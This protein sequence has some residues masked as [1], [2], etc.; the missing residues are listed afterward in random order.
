MTP[1]PLARLRTICLAFPEAHEVLA[2]GEPTFRVRNRLFAMFA[3]PSHHHGAGRPAVW[4]KATPINQAL[5]VKAKPSRFFVPPYVGKSGWVGVWLD[6]RP[7]WGEVASLL[8]DAWSAT[9]PK[10]LVTGAL[11]MLRDLATFQ[12]DDGIAVLARTPATFRALLDGLPGDWIS[13]H[14]GPDTFS[15]FDNVGHLIH[16]E[17]TDWI[18]RA[19]IILA[20]GANRRFEPYDRFAQFRESEGKSLAQ[21]LDEFAELRA[22][23]VATLRG[24][25]LTDRELALEGEHPSLGSVSLRQLLATWV[26]H[27]LGHIAQTSRVMAKRYREAVGPWR[28]Y[29]PVLEV[30]LMKR[31]LA[32]VIV[33]VLLPALLAA[34]P[35]RRF[36]PD[37]LVNT[38]VIPKSTPVPQVLG[39][40]RGFAGDLGVRCQ[41]CHV[42]EEGKPLGEFDFASDDK[43]TKLVARQMMR[44]VAEINHRIDT[45]P[46]RTASTSVQVSCRTCHRGVS[47]P[48]PLASLVADAAQAAGADSA[49][50]AYRAMRARHYGGDAYDFGEPSLSDAAFRL[51]RAGRFDDAMALLTLNESF[52]PASSALYVAR[53]DVQLM[54]RD[55]TAAEAAFREALRRD[56]ANREAR[57]RIRA[58]GRT[59]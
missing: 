30:R 55:T 47:K 38:K 27:D 53:G 42:G 48:V 33:V 35:A 8:R 10:S 41:F 46:G 32:V 9:A 37:S 2:W 22:A 43:R 56:S 3:S 13:A 15:P 50:R 19:R 44:M 17:R 39:M 51:G 40:M 5:M 57:G 49:I 18:P 23:N 6:R 45:L 7:A 21:L 31:M 16:G 11:T 26:A 20:Q 25:T 34:Q 36:P 4:V 52:Y 14:E 28:Q 58:I 1:P 59:P 54:R 12:L 29:L 24:W